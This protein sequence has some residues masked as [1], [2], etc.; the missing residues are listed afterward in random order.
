MKLLASPPISLAYDEKIYSSFPDIIRDPTG[1]FLCVYRE[2]DTHHPTTSKLILLS[3]PDAIA[4]KRYELAQASMEEHGCVF[5]CP[6]LGI[7]DEKVVVFCDVKSS[8]KEAFAKWD[9]F[10]WTLSANSK[11]WGDP[12]RLGISG[13]VPDRIIQLK[14]KIVM[15]YH[16]VENIEGFERLSQMMAESYD[17]GR[18]WRDR[19]TIAASDQHFFCE[20]SIVEMSN[21]TLVCYMRDNRGPLLRAYYAVSH[22]QGKDWDKP[23][24]MNIMAHRI[25]AAVKKIQ[26]Y[27]GAVLG[28]FRNTSNKTL[29]LF[30]QNPKNNKT[31]IL[32]IDKETHPGLYD[33][34][35]SGWTE[36][37]DGGLLVVYYIRRNKPNPEICLTKVD[38]V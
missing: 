13:M 7:I 24:Q 21:A 23:R 17:G 38:L 19:T 22:N 29:S 27:A 33:Y 16:V 2:A 35:Y 1:D 4:W 15:G 37:K 30:I 10:M 18:T 8:Q 32:P 6:K 11:R 12:A 28:T 20:G 31:Q 3:S 25:V 26:P 34:G 14:K 5:N 9:T 36:T